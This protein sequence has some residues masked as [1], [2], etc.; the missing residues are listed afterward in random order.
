M[1]VIKGEGPSPA[2]ITGSLVSQKAGP[3][4]SHLSPTLS[5]LVPSAWERVCA[6]CRQACVCGGVRVCVVRSLGLHVLQSASGPGLAFIVFT[7][8]VLHMPGA[9]AWAVLFFGM[10]FTLGLSTMF[11]G[12]EAVITPMLDVGVLPRWVPKEALTGECTA[13]PPWRTRPQHPA[14]HSH[15]LSRRPSWMES[16]R[17]Q[18]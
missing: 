10:L 6:F 3:A 12:M 1:W 4:L 13:R 9:P 14:I 8:A 16:T 18:A 7:E 5:H 2:E 11:G 17:G 15:L